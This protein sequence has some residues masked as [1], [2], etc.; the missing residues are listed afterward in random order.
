MPIKA[1]GQ[2]IQTLQGSEFYK[3]VI[4]EGTAGFNL[5]GLIMSD[6]INFNFDPRYSPL[7][8]V[9]AAA[10]ERLT[11]IAK[12]PLSIF[13]SGKTAKHQLMTRAAWEETGMFML[14]LPLIF[15]AT[16]SEAGKD[17][18]LIKNAID[19]LIDLSFPRG[20][21]GGENLQATS[22]NGTNILQDIVGTLASAGSA[23]EA[24]MGYSGGVGFDTGILTVSIGNWFYASNYFVCTG[25][26][27]EESTF[28]SQ[29][30]YPL[31]MSAIVEL[32]SFQVPTANEVKSWF[33]NPNQTHTGET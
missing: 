30:G 17:E 25:V 26:Q 28:Y 22:N 18:G 7:H 3:V 27:M 19:R 5:E 9:L 15:V 6:S 24:P 10:G 2:E 21:A 1:T 31:V 11:S 13:G 16:S 12:G 32:T 20:F 33:K 29:K 4:T 8:S 23:L 14:N